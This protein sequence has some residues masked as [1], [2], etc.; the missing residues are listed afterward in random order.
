MKRVLDNFLIIPFFLNFLK[1]V[2]YN[3]SKAQ[4]HQG[5]VPMK[6]NQIM[7]SR[8]M[9]SEIFSALSIQNF[10]MK[11]YSKTNTHFF[12][13]IKLTKSYSHCWIGGP[14][15]HLFCRLM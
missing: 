5:L 2:N 15:L 14:L 6:Y 11:A 4:F 10:S 8:W 7:F 9:R 1:I 12:S 13:L 3:L